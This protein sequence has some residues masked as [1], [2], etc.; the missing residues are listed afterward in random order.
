MT[1]GRRGFDRP[2]V[3]LSGAGVSGPAVPRIILPVVRIARIEVVGLAGPEHGGLVAHD[4]IVGMLASGALH[5]LHLAGAP[6]DVSGLNVTG[7]AEGMPR[8]VDLLVAVLND[9]LDLLLH[10]LVD[11]H[12]LLDDDLDDPLHRL[13]DDPLDL[14]VDR[15]LDDLLDLVSTGRSTITSWTISTSRSMTLSTRTG[16]VLHRDGADRRHDV[17]LRAEG[18]G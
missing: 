18:R 15:L 14:D 8:D 12:R 10:V 9:P 5:P 16:L 4:V 1:P 13:L 3:M 11:D 17:L 7:L 2:G 6:L